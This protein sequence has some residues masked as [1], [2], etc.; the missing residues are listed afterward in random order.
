M[1]VGHVRHRH[2][3]GHVGEERVVGGGEHFEQV[4]DRGQAVALA[5][6]V[7]GAREVVEH[8]R[9]RFADVRQLTQTVVFADSAQA[10]CDFST[11]PTCN[12]V[13][14]QE[15]FYPKREIEKGSGT[16]PGNIKA[17]YRRKV[18]DP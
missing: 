7:H 16:F 4:T 12:K 9:H 10:G 2:E 5:Q 11:W 18:P 17:N 8:E 1:V 13:N 15:N 6:R 14:F 3:L